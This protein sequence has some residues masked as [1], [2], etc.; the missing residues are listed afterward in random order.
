M[1]S[2]VSSR[3]NKGQLVVIVAVLYFDTNQVGVFLF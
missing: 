2:D 3:C 1:S